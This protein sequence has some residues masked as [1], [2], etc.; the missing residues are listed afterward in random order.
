MKESYLP[1]YVKYTARAPFIFLWDM[2]FHSASA[3]Q[4]TALG[5][6]LRD[7]AKLNKNDNLLRL[8][9]RINHILLEEK[10]Q[11]PDHA[12]G[13]G[14]L[15]QS[16]DEVSL[17]GLRNTTARV[18]AMGLRNFCKNAFV[19]DIGCNSG[20]LDIAIAPYARQIIGFDI[21]PYLIDIGT[22]AL[23]YLKISNVELSALSFETFESKEP[24][25]IVLSF[26]NHSTFDGNTEQTVKMY[27]EKCHTI[28]RTGGLL[29]FESH[30]PTYES[31]EA[32]EETYKIIQKMFSIKER[33]I[34]QSKNFFD[35]GRTFI[36]AQK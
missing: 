4:R 33:R 25:D 14:Y 5:Y 20:F 19:V 24:A 8:H 28:L 11:W 15:Y 31:K 32:L 10:K 12:Y 7:Y 23:A 27:I 16:C 9:E 6:R 18:T 17:G 2:I 26:A 34:L 3:A 13:E 36:V 29:L 30:H 1:Y 35:N 21:N 22:Q